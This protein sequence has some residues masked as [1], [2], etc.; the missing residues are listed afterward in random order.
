MA[1][2]SACRAGL[3]T[4]RRLQR[5]PDLGGRC[6]RLSIMK[7][8][9]FETILPHAGGSLSVKTLTAAVV[10]HISGHGLTGA[11]RIS[12]PRVRV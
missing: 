6:I 3:T 1:C 4:I 5:E 8:R 2:R 7:R 12:G 10:G 11:G 9:R